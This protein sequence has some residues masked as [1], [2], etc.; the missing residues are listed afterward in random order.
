MSSC[1]KKFTIDGRNT[2]TIIVIMIDIRKTTN[3]ASFALLT[4]G[5]F[6]ILGNSTVQI[7]ETG[8]CINPLILEPTS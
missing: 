7:T 5:F 8:F 6:A 1:M 2:L 4:F 3:M